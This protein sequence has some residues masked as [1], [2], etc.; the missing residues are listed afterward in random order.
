[1]LIRGSLCQVMSILARQPKKPK[2]EAV[3]LDPRFDL[4]RIT[5]SKEEVDVCPN[6]IRAYASE[7][8]R[9]YRCGRCLFYS[10]TELE[11]FI[12]TRSQMEAA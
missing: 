1:M 10:V 12:R 9:L 3:K 8:L 6:T 7:G 11:H 5:K 2:Q 4:R